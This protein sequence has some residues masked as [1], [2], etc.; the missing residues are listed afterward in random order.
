MKS[1]EEMLD[2][3]NDECDTCSPRELCLQAMESYATQQTAELQQEVEGLKGAI[4][5]IG[6]HLRECNYIAAYRYLQ[7]LNP[8]QDEK[9]G[10]RNH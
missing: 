4:I 10:E 7:A 5:E 2:Q 8:Q 3:I 1:K 9:T 6:N